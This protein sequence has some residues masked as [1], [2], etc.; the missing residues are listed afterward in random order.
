MSKPLTIY[1]PSSVSVDQPIGV[2]M[3]GP[4]E[5]DPYKD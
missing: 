3:A 2:V 5:Y 1:S 4:D